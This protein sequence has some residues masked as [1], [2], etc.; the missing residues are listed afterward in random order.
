MIVLICT[1]EPR[2]LNLLPQLIAHYR[3]LGVERF[4]FTLHL[5]PAADPAANEQ[6]R[7][8]F[9]R[10]LEHFDIGDR[11]YFTDAFDSDAFYGHKDKLQ[12][13]LVADSDWIVWVDSDEFQLY[14][15]PLP[16]I[17]KE[18]EA[19]NI[20]F[21]RGVLIDRVGPEGTL[22]AFNPARPIWQQ[23]PLACTITRHIAGGTTYKV[24]LARGWLQV[25]FG[26][27][28]PAI[29]ETGNAPPLRQASAA[30]RALKTL[31]T[32]VQ[33]HHFKWESG[34]IDR[35]RERITPQMKADHA[36]WV[37]S[38]RLLNY[39]KANNLRFNP[40]DIREMSAVGPKLLSQPETSALS[41][42]S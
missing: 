28:L 20:D 27:H 3:Q 38:Q 16:A 40:S 5:D 1:V 6:G 33:V 12:E 24:A 19:H 23:Y 21:L 41:P 11:F 17:I 34:V 30:R 14:P 26:H 36:H 35:L 9:H 22:P 4:L 10:I 8:T 42:R 37:E 31:K 29:M 7:E 32:H 18:L 39:F 2:R 13:T 15:K 25:T